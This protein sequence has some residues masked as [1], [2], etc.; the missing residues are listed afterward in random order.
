MYVVC[1]VCVVQ[2]IYLVMDLCAGGL[3]DRIKQQGPF[4]EKVCRWVEGGGRSEELKW[5]MLL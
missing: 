1:V 2:K 3:S 4:A 5:C